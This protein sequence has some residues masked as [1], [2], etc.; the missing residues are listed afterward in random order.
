MALEG[1]RLKYG[2]ASAWWKGDERTERH[3]CVLMGSEGWDITGHVGE[4]KNP[5]KE[6]LRGSFLLLKEELMADSYPHLL[7]HFWFHWE[8]SL[9]PAPTAL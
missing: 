7:T 1:E 8:R 3:V 6:F 2:L 4:G 9:V 5:T